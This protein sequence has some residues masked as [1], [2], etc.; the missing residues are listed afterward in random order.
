MWWDG[1]LFKNRPVPT[2][3][4]SG[5]S[6]QEACDYRGGRCATTDGHPVHLVPAGPHRP[7]LPRAG[8]YDVPGGC[9]VLRQVIEIVENERCHGQ[10]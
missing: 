10:Q 2:P 3:P 8:P 1:T 9:V 6:E 7:S 5:V 4:P